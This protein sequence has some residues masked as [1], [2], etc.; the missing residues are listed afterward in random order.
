MTLE[1]GNWPAQNTK[2]ILASVTRVFKTG[3]TNKL[4]KAA[5][6]HITLHMGFIAH[7]SKNGF[8]DVY[9]DIDKFARTLLTSE[10]SNEPEYN[11]RQ[12]GR[13]MTDLWFAREYGQAY[14]Q[15]VVDCNKGILGIVRK[16]LQ[17]K[18]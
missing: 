15:S 2:G 9:R 5:Y 1:K 14:C 4:T 12:A 13:Y 10:Y 17:G 11:G 7:Y 8:A 18:L 16:Y 6:Q 3:D